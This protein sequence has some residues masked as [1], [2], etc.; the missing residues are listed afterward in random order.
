MRLTRVPVERPAVVGQSSFELTEGF[1]GHAA[2]E[3]GFGVIGP[4]GEDTTELGQGA[5][6][7]ALL[8][9]GSP[10]ER[11]DAGVA[12]RYLFGFGEE[13]E[14]LGGWGEAGELEAGT[15]LLGSSGG[16]FPP[17]AGF[18]APS[19]GAGGGEES[20]DGKHGEKGA[21]GEQPGGGER[22]GG[23]GE[24]EPAPGDEV[25]GREEGGAGQ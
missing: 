9:V 5:G 8:Q 21:A 4:L 20:E 12:R 16:G 15:E 11:C 25:G 23:H 14:G 18:V 17:E 10:F 24:V 13:G 7:V 2:V 22:E 3:D 6:G 19:D 1:E